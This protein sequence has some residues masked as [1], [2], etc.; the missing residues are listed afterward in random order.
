[1]CGLAQ[2]G[3]FR[4]WHMG[5]GDMDVRLG[6]WGQ[7][8]GSAIGRV[9]ELQFEQPMT[10]ALKGVG[11]SRCAAVLMQCS[12]ACAARPLWVEIVRIVQAS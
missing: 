2:S 12:L 4:N 3:F 11:A 5:R 6:S 1:M 10:G 7:A 9:R 8:L